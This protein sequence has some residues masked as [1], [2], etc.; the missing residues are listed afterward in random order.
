MDAAQPCIQLKQVDVESGA[1]TPISIALQGNVLRPCTSSKA[2][3]LLELH[4]QAATL[5][6]MEERGK[7]LLLH[8]GNNRD[9]KEQGPDATCKTL[10][11]QV[12][13]EQ[14]EQGPDATCKQR[15]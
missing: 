7:D 6:A 3:G 4:Q 15:R 10:I 11:I 5:I 8:A 1:V 14:K 9:E 12:I 2:T 13:Q